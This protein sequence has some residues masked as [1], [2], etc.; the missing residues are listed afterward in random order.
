MSSRAAPDLRIALYSH[1]LS[2]QPLTIADISDQDATPTGSALSSSETQP[3]SHV[4]QPR[5]P[6]HGPNPRQLCYSMSLAAPLRVT[7]TLL[8]CVRRAMSDEVEDQATLT[9]R[10]V[11]VPVSPSLN[12]RRA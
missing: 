3:T 9:V 7:C 11:A 5:A 12:G 6:R 10:S 2:T 4:R 1:S 8:P